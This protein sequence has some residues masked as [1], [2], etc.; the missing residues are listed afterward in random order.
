MPRDSLWIY[1]Q[2]SG[3]V[4]L[5]WRIKVCKKGWGVQNREE[6][7]QIFAIFV[8][9][10]CRP[11]CEGVTLKP[12][13]FSSH[14]L[15]FRRP[16]CEVVALK[17]MLFYKDY[18]S[19]YRSHHTHKEDCSEG[20]QRPFFNTDRF[21]CRLARKHIWFCTVQA[22]RK[23]LFSGSDSGEYRSLWYYKWFLCDFS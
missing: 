9:I 8:G 7:I 2:Q 13:L 6:F 12:H 16:P 22:C 5:N 4:I 17:K 19:F 15:Y 14:C 11:P 3:K 21:V 20:L 10:C 1:E 18:C 23:D